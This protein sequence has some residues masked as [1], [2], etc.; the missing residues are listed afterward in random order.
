MGGTFDPIHYGH[1][2][3]AELAR[4][5]YGLSRVIFVPAGQPPHKEGKVEAPA[6]DRYMMT[7]LA[8][9]DNPN[10]AVSR[11]ELDAEGPSY[12]LE[13]VRHFQD[14]VEKLY[15]IMGS[16]SLLEM[17][18]WHAWDE[19]AEVCDFIVASRP[20]FSLAEKDWRELLPETVQK[21]IYFLDGPNLKIAATEI[22]ERIKLKKSFRYLLPKSVQQYIINRELYRLV[23]T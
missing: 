8:T 18:T 21:K 4:V 13:T 22:R 20:G 2:A 12:T 3:V 10:F 19:L 7:V 1:L 14:S 17:R 16:D 6:E 5:T 15:F 9:S 23:Q 11:W